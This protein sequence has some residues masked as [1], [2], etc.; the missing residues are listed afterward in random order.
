MTHLIWSTALA[1]TGRVGATTIAIPVANLVRQALAASPEAPVR[2]AF[3]VCTVGSTTFGI[4]ATYFNLLTTRSTAVDMFASALPRLDFIDHPCGLALLQWGT[5][6]AVAPVFVRALAL[7]FSI[8]KRAPS[9]F[10]YAISTTT[11]T[12]IAAAFLQVRV[13]NDSAE[14]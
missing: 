9:M 7:A 11:P 10:R 6:L 4:S 13:S 14:R 3:L 1:I 5:T 12:P 2:T 8:A